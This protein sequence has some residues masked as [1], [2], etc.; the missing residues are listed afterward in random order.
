MVNIKLVQKQ[1]TISTTYKFQSENG[2]EISP[3]I[4]KKQNVLDA[5]PSTKKVIDGYEFVTLKQGENN[6]W[7]WVYKKISPTQ[8]QVKVE[9][10]AAP[11]TGIEK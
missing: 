2:E 5:D 7:I 3:D 1:P 4:I 9:K 8:V 10:I 11:N 6:T